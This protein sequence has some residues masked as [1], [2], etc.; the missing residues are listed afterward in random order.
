MRQTWNT[1]DHPEHSALADEART[2]ILSLR[3]YDPLVDHRDRLVTSVHNAISRKTLHWL[4]EGVAKLTMASAANLDAATPAASAVTEPAPAATDLLA[5][6]KSRRRGR[7][8]GV[9]ANGEK[10]RQLRPE[11]YKQ[12]SFATDCGLSPAAYRKAETGKRVDIETLQ[13]IAQHATTRLGKPTTVD[14]LTVT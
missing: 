10:V 12:F 14:E 4:A 9:L 1:F 7:E 2:M 13:K 5:A 3:D 11:G 8:P 6:V